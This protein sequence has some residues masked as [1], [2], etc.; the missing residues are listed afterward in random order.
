MSSGKRRPAGTV[1][2]YRLA[3]GSTAQ[4]RKQPYAS[5]CRD[6]VASALDLENDRWTPCPAETGSPRGHRAHRGKD[7]CARRAGDGKRPPCSPWLILPPVVPGGPGEI[8]RW[9]PCQAERRKALAGDFP[10][11]CT[12][13]IRPAGATSPA[14]AGLHGRRASDLF[15]MSN[16]DRRISPPHYSNNI[17]T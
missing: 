8:E 14:A 1:D 5:A 7:D 12:H 6:R 15:T 2:P 4:T 13:V 17:R 9:T 11:N 10:F 3:E 16:I